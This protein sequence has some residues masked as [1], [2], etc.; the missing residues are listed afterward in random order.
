[1]NSN[2][3]TK[4]KQSITNNS[5]VE[6][7]NNSL[8][9]N[10]AG[11]NSL[12]A[13]YLLEN[14]KNSSQ[15]NLNNNNTTI[16]NKEEAY[17]EA[18]RIDFEKFMETHIQPTLNALRTQ[19]LT[20]QGFDQKG[21]NFLPQKSEAMK[22]KPAIK[23]THDKY[24]NQPGEKMKKIEKII[25]KLNVEYINQIKDTDI[26]IKNRDDLIMEMNK[27]NAEVTKLKQNN[28]DEALLHMLK[29][30]QEIEMTLKDLKN[31]DKSELKLKEEESCKLVEELNELFEQKKKDA[32][33]K[34]DERKSAI[35]E[36]KQL[37]KQQEEFKKLNN[38]SLKK[39]E[40]LIK[41]LELLDEKVETFKN[42]KNFIDQVIENSNEGSTNPVNDYEKLKEK[43]ENLIE[44]MTEIQ[45]DI[46]DQ[47]NQIV[48]LKKEQAD[49]MRKNDKQLQNQKILQLEEET[50]NYIRENKILEKE[51]E[52]ILKKN[53][54]KES[55]TH[56]IKLS[57]INLY[58]KV[59]NSNECNIDLDD[60]E[61]CEKLN[62]INEKII[63]LIK[64][65]KQLE[66]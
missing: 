4:N 11:T 42:Y 1:M 55:D 3:E 30:N 28:R 2:T 48:K 56:Q 57:I 53:Q 35:E 54:K 44:R 64:I 6:N 10:K 24:D 38:Q 36:I 16:L 62:D 34:D 12:S 20:N 25:R 19:K 13:N 43:F 15:I 9:N 17:A 61:L 65:H 52:E 7:N 59:N 50:K 14:K 29:E 27:Y 51:I 18:E 63:D 49:L 40:E 47:E 66:P 39:K 5:I 46:I 21:K 22:K 32:I 41:E 31:K 37:K 33:E 60:N 23:S 26:K 45:N 8:S 58:N